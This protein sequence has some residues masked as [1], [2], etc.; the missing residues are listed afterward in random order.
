MEI[1]FDTNINVSSGLQL[2]QY[3][4]VVDP[5]LASQQI[6]PSA[7]P[8]STEQSAFPAASVAPV[9]PQHSAAP[10]VYNTQTSQLVRVSRPFT[11]S[12]ISFQLRRSVMASKVRLN[13]S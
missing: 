3:A 11:F 7:A 13:C 4:G 1:G 10:V 5:S 2:V 8:L 12:L 6:Y 9:V